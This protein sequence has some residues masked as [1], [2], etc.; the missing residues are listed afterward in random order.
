MK[1]IFFATLFVFFVSEGF[2]QSDSSNYKTNKNKLKFGL[3]Y[4]CFSDLNLNFIEGVNQSLM[5]ITKVNNHI[6]KIGPTFFL[7]P[8]ISNLK[9]DGIILSYQYILKTNFNRLNVVFC[10]DLV[11]RQRIESWIRELEYENYG[12]TNVKFYSKSNSIQNLL[13]Y[14]FKFNVNQKFSLIT[15]M[16]IGGEIYNFKSKTVPLNQPFL[17]NEYSSGNIFSNRKNCNI[18][19]IGIEYFFN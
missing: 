18:I 14:G 4:F 3:S 7:N 5:I 6:I 19:K 1:N 17:S 16:G 13:G 9:T 10:Y 2:P 15:C 8:R 11:Y 12:K